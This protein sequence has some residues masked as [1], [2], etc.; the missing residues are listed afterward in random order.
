[1]IGTYCTDIFIDILIHFKDLCN[2]NQ[3]Y[4]TYITII[5][6]KIN[7]PF[8]KVLKEVFNVNTDHINVQIFF[9]INLS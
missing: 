9:K 7:T 2:L 5:Y 3:F 6:G 1:M 8:A 4:W